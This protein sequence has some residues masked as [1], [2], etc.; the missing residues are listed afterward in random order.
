MGIFARFRSRTAS[1]LSASVDEAR[2]RE[3]SRQADRESRTFVRW[4]DSLPGQFRR[5]LTRVNKTLGLK[6]QE[7]EITDADI[8][9]GESLYRAQVT[10][11]D[12]AVFHLTCDVTGEF[13]TES[14]LSVDGA[15]V[16]R[17][18]RT[19]AGDIVLPSLDEVRAALAAALTKQLARPQITSLES[20]VEPVE[21]PASELGPRAGI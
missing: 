15:D 12:G 2:A 11:E 18:A 21:S 9:A 4:A 5:E 14:V 10:L 7:V 20:G 6:P 17:F 19:Y 8:L 3:E 16:G 13:V 1:D